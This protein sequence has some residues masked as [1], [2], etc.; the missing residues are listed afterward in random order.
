MKGIQLL[1]DAQLQFI[2]LCNRQFRFDRDVCRQT[3]AMTFHVSKPREQ[4]L[5]VE[6]QESDQEFLQTHRRA[7]TNII[8][9]QKNYKALQ[10]ISYITQIMMP[11]YEKNLNT[12]SV[13]ESKAYQI[14][15]ANQDDQ[16]QQQI[17]NDGE[18]WIDYKFEIH[19]IE[20]KQDFVNVQKLRQLE[21]YYYKI[22]CQGEAVPLTFT[23]NQS[24][25]TKFKV[26][27][28]TTNPFPSKFSCEQIYQVKT[29]KYKSKDYKQFRQKFIFISLVCDLDTTIKISFTF[30]STQGTQ[31]IY[32]SPISK[33]QI[34]QNL[35]NCDLTASQIIKKRKK[36]ML[37]LSKGRNLIQ[38]NILNV[39]IQN[40]ECIKSQK[41]LYKTLQQKKFH[42]VVKKRKQLEINTQGQKQINYFSKEITHLL[43]K[44]KQQKEMDQNRY[45]KSEIQFEMFRLIAYLQ[46]I[47]IIYERLKHQHKIIHHV[48]IIQI[49]MKTIYFRAKRNMCRLKGNTI[50][51]RVHLDVKFCLSMIANQ[52]KK[53]VRIQNINKI[54]P[55][56]TQ[57]SLLWNFKE[58][59]HQTSK[60]LQ[61]IKEAIYSFVLRYRVYKQFLRSIF[62]KNFDQSC[63]KYISNQDLKIQQQFDLWHQNSKYMMYFQFLSK[64]FASLYGRQKL[65]AFFTIL[66]KQK[67]SNK[68]Y[69]KDSLLLVFSKKQENNQII[70]LFKVPLQDDFQ[71]MLPILYEQT[72]GGAPQYCKDQIRRPFNKLQL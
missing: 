62:E 26:F 59:I 63:Q 46:L 23:M 39:T 48:Q 69:R 1:K 10:Q 18:I 27:L 42:D 33:Q 55:I 9:P 64:T 21:F 7:T 5:S 72:K 66:R 14:Q 24:E 19:P 54:Q 41:Q 15:L 52:I 53:K 49:K 28:S 8:N 68:I 3:H 47:N 51:G 16:R 71:Q 31:T 20:L 70:S 11:D 12:I 22:R 60:N 58:K 35:I 44:L 2:I 38:E 61:I 45:L 30:G 40:D 6:S 32:K 4:S 17:L 29:W 36:Q 13:I 65:K 57:R 67:Q 25:Q 34:K 56:L 37:E 50:F 43:K